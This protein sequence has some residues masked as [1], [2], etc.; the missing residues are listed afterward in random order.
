[1]GFTIDSRDPIL[2]ITVEWNGLV[3]KGK[4]VV[5]LEN[6]FPLYR[7]PQTYEVCDACDFGRHQCPMCGDDLTHAE[8][9]STNGHRHPCFE[10]A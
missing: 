1:M 7:H 6:I 4:H 9:R 10:E 8:A 2:E 5:H 3:G